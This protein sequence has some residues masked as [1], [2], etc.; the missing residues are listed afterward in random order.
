M[1][2]RPGV[3]YFLRYLQQ[4]Y[5]LV[6]FTSVP[7]HIAEP[8]IAKLDPFRIVTWPL[9]R[10]ATRYKNGEYIK[11]CRVKLALMATQR[12]ICFP[13]QDLS[14]LN[15]DLSKVIL[16]DTVP[17]HAKNQPENAIILPKWKGDKNDKELVSLIPFLE[18]VATM[19]FSDTRSVL[20]SFEGKHIPS[21]FA[22]REKVARE[23]FER[24]LAE[25]R[26]HRSKRIGKGLMNSLL[27][28]RPGQGMQGGELSPAEAFEEGKMLQDQIR[29][30]GQKQ[31]EALEKE[32]RENGDKWLSEMAAETKKMT[33]EQ[34]KGMKNSIA[35]VFVGGGVSGNNDA[36][37]K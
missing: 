34:M 8:V 37:K 15:R 2:K 29:E 10:E 33:D 27:G 19:G 30:R 35:S 3:D 11:V 13:L 18:Y 5:E 25:E 17:S 36:S 28:I 24:E 7:S 26:G 9:F 14:F 21:E 32:I 12:L 6:I 16:L 1:A 22:A 31:Y 20:K 23:K 4:Y